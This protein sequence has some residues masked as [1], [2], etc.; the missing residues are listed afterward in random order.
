MDLRVQKKFKGATFSASGGGTKWWDS[1]HDFTKNPLIDRIG[2]KLSS[3][4]Q[5]GIGSI[6]PLAYGGGMLRLQPLVIAGSLDILPRKMIFIF[7]TA[8]V[9]HNSGG[10]NLDVLQFHNGQHAGSWVKIF[11][12]AA[13]VEY[14]RF[15]I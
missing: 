3:T 9:S 13:C 4:R 5:L 7:K 10:S 12:P 8:I 11:N 1:I 14:H 2:R 6:T 15:P